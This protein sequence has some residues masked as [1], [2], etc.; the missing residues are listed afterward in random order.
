[1]SKKAWIACEELRRLYEDEQMTTVT[2]S[3]H[4]GR[5]ITTVANRLRRCGIALRV[6]RYQTK[7]VSPQELQQ[8]YVEERLP[9]TVIADHFGV[10]LSTIYNRLQVYGLPLRRKK[11]LEPDPVSAME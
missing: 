4:Y 9:V 11:H 1:M 5:S 8:L 7:A 3:R 2:I 6:G 10:C